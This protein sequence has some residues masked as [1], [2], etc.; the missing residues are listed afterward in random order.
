[1]GKHSVIL[2]SLCVCVMSQTR[3][4]T[5]AT[6]TSLVTGKDALD[7]VPSPQ[8]SAAQKYNAASRFVLYTAV[9]SALLTKS[10]STALLY[11]ALGLGG[12]NLLAAPYFLHDDVDPSATNAATEKF[13]YDAKALRANDV[14]NAS[15][16]MAQRNKD[17]LARSPLDDVRFTT[18]RR[19]AYGFA[20][21]LRP[22]SDSPND[23]A[24]SQEDAEQKTFNKT[25]LY[26]V[27]VASSTP[28]LRSELQQK[29]YSKF[30]SPDA[31]V[32]DGSN[33]PGLNAANIQ[34]KKPNLSYLR[35]GVSAYSI[36]FPQKSA[37]GR[38]TPSEESLRYP[39]GI[40]GVGNVTRAQ[41]FQQAGVPDFGSQPPTPFRLITAPMRL[42]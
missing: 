12:L 24:T 7:V 15:N 20:T 2:V 10:K 30:V 27:D 29:Q 9:L 13:S 31:V 33:Q 23:V 8:M 19:D 32:S 38:V 35:P 22:V 28:S 4:W 16:A 26:G 39:G 41:V 37:R 25:S 6:I 3:M 40:R 11:G 5:P 36:M 1:M 18:P 42:P 34:R 21:G 17:I 14:V